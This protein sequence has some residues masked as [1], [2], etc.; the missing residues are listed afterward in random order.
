MTSVNSAA[1]T[2]ALAADSERS[3]LAK[4]LERHTLAA[5]L[6][7]AALGFCLR[8]RGLDRAGF[9][10]DEVQKINAARA[11]LRGDFSRNSTFFPPQREVIF[12]CTVLSSSVFL[13]PTET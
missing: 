3:T 11:Y 10:E 1:P 8:M 9:N 4:L 13:H 5:L 7:I 12:Q 2:M 6:L